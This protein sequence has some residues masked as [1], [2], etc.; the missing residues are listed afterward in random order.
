MFVLV[1]SFE[2]MSALIQPDCH[3]VVPNS[4]PYISQLS[5]EP[6]S[7]VNHDVSPHFYSIFKTESK[8]TGEEK[9]NTRADIKQEFLVGPCPT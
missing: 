2:L 8:Q 7:A 1:I 9:K 3:A 4:R 5:L 6:G